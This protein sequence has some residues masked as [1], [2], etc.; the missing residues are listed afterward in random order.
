MSVEFCQNDFLHLLRWSH[1]FSLF[2]TV[3]MVNYINWFSNVKP[4][5]IPVINTHRIIPF[6]T[7]LD[8]YLLIFCWKCMLLCSWGILIYSILIISYFGTQIILVMNFKIFLPLLFPIR[9]CVEFILLFFLTICWNSTVKSPEARVIFVET[10]FLGIFSLIDME[11]FR[12]SLLLEWVPVVVHLVRTFYICL[13]CQIYW[14]KVGY[15]VPLLYFN[16]CRVYSSIPLSWLMLAI[17]VNLWFVVSLAK[18]LSILLIF[19]KT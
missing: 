11:L 16:F 7:L 19:S 2:F 10:I 18:G 15:N 4:Y 6:Q 9:V 5:S 13:S 1:G 3:N 14:H 17:F 12:L 8:F